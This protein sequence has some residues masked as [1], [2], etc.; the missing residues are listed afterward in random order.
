MV[1]WQWTRDGEKVASIT[2]RP[3][4]D[5]LHL[6]Y[7]LRLC[8]GE[9]EDVAET[10]RVIYVSCHFGGARPYFICPGEVNGL[11]CGRHVAKLYLS[12]RHFLCRHCGRLS[13]ASQTEDAWDR[14]LRRAKKIRK[15]LGGNPAGAAGFPGRPKGMWRR[16]YERLR[17]QAF[18]AEMLADD[19]FTLGAERIVARID[20]P[21]RNRRWAP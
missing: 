17:D 1:G 13:H 3:E 14:A 18:D 4:E 7:R 16:T 11:S 12:G 6:F 20:K 9:W 2:L 19:F 15:R 5:R 8:G 10:V 21:K